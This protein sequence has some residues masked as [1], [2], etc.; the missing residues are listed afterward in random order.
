MKVDGIREEAVARLVGINK[1]QLHDGSLQRH[2]EDGHFADWVRRRKR[3]GEGRAIKKLKL[4]VGSFVGRPGRC[5][6]DLHEDAGMTSMLLMLLHCG[7]SRFEAKLLVL[8]VLLVN[9]D[10]GQSLT[11]T[12][13]L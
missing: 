12:A 9:P 1:V 11:S 2:H 5:S 6:F 3:V 8:L 4:V 7:A 10:P 13:M